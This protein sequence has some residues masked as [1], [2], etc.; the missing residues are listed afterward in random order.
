MG[1]HNAAGRGTSR[2]R[3]TFPTRRA[4]KVRATLAT[5]VV[6]GLGSVGTMAAWSESVEAT[7]GVFS[8]SSVN[9]TVDGQDAIEFASLSMANMI[10]GSTENAN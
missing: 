2:P 9:I 10:P 3:W 4:D 1:R 7:S 8:T 6:L 5:G